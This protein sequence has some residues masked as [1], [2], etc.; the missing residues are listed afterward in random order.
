MKHHHHHHSSCHCHKKEGAIFAQIPS[1][2]SVTVHSSDKYGQDN[3]LAVNS[4]ALSYTTLCGST[5]FDT[6]LCVTVHSFDKYGQDN[7]LA[8]NSITL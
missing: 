4:I 7:L 5:L 3:L 1:R 6:A 8:L 2:D